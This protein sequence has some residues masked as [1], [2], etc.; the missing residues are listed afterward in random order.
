[1]TTQIQFDGLSDYHFYVVA[2]CPR[3][4]DS[5]FTAGQTRLAAVRAYNVGL[6][7]FPKPVY[8]IVVKFNAERLKQDITLY[9]MVAPSGNVH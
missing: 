5:W 4:S 1:V 2:V 3:E 8:R 6:K 9:E 7:Q